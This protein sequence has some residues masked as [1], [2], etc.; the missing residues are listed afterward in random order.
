MDSFAGVHHLLGRH[1][2][3][4][5]LGDPGVSARSGAVMGEAGRS[6]DGWS[7]DAAWSIVYTHVRLPW[8]ELNP[9]FL[10]GPSR[11]RWFSELRAYLI[12]AASRAVAR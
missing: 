2:L 9:G 10:D 4:T 3:V 12:D 8:G 7:G 11:V 5:A 6:G 1:R